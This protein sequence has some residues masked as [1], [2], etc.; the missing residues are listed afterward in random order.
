MEKTSS[1]TI[2]IVNVQIDAQCA[3]TQL[4]NINMA[5]WIHQGPRASHMYTLLSMCT[6]MCVFL[7]LGISCLLTLYFSCKQACSRAFAFGQRTKCGRTQPHIIYCIYYINM[8]KNKAAC[9]TT[10]AHSLA[11][12]HL[13]YT[14]VVWSEA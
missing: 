4:L 14:Y 10:L 8:H 12:V 9:H 1:F 6:R 13:Y 2:S 3:Y 7:S 11:S 5:E